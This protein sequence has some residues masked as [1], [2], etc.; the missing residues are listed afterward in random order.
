[1]NTNPMLRVLLVAMVLLCV[2]SGAAAEETVH[3]IELENGEV[4][5]GIVV[6]ASACTAL[7]QTDDLSLEV[8]LQQIRA[9]DGKSDL[10][11]S[12]LRDGRPLL[13]F[14]TFEELL[15]NGDVVLHASF[16]RRNAGGQTIQEIDWGV[17]PH[18]LSML[19]HWQVFD[20]LGNALPL[21]IEDREDGGKQVH[22]TLVRP[23]LPGETVQFTD[24]ILQ[25]GFVGQKD[26]LFLYRHRGDYPDDRLVTRML[27]LPSGAQVVSVSPEPVQRLEIAGSPVVVWRR[28]FVAGEELPFELTYRLK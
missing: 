3:E 18:E 7:V 13:R 6:P 28:Y 12:L 5:K 1:M 23:I 20:A 15:P 19:E 26:G 4:L 25:Q 27:R 24:R 8:P 11:V 2:A 14:D 21:R 16:S 22:A 17:A 9:L 10:P